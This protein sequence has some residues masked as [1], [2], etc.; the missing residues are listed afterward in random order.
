MDRLKKDGKAIC[1][2]KFQSG[3]DDMNLLLKYCD[4]YGILN[5]V[6]N[7]NSNAFYERKVFV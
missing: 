2:K 3:L 5:K 7:D 4:L 1:N 6:G